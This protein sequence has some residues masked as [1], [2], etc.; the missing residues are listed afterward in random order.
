MRRDAKPLRETV[1]AE[2]VSASD[3]SLPGRE[4]FILE[5]PRGDRQKVPLDHPA[6]RRRSRS[7]VLRVIATERLPARVD[8]VAPGRDRRQQ[9]RAVHFGVVSADDLQG[10]PSLKLV[11][12]HGGV[13]FRI[14]GAAAGDIAEGRAR[15]QMDSAHHRADQALDMP[16]IMR[17]GDRTMHQRNAVFRSPSRERAAAK[18]AAVVDVNHVRQARD[19]PVSVHATSLEPLGFRHHEVVDRQSDRRRRWRFQ[20]EIETGHHA[21]RHVD[22]ERQPRALN[23][24][25]VHRVDDENVDGRVV[26]LDNLKRIVGAIF[27]DDRFEAVAR[28]LRAFPRANER[29]PIDGRHTRPNGVARRYGDPSGPAQLAN[30]IVQRADRPLLAG[31]IMVANRLF[32]QGFDVIGETARS[33]R[34]TLLCAKH[35]ARHRLASVP[36]DQRVEA[37]AAYAERAAGRFDFRRRQRPPAR[38]RPDDRLPRHRLPPLVAV[39]IELID[40]ALH[41][42]PTSLSRHSSESGINSTYLSR[43]HSTMARKKC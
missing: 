9:K 25:T 2:V 40:L 3:P 6:A 28:C 30:M 35:R 1:G 33:P 32:D 24:P 4:Q 10:E 26:D 36:F 38:E 13:F 20:T 43:I 42:S 23:R 5:R 34:R 8:G 31:K 17:R 27:P 37:R 7:S 21:A 12:R 18:L 41:M 11:K 39:D 16:A 15:Q 14:I 22:R 29:A 19:R